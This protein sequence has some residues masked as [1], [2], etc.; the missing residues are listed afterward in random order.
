M[1]FRH[2][3]GH[4]KLLKNTNLQLFKKYTAHRKPKALKTNLGYEY[5]MGKKNQN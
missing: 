1:V 4:T 5:Q 2:L 3:I